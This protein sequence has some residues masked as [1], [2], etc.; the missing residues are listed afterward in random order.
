MI[1]TRT[2]PHMLKV[3]RKETLLALWFKHLA[4]YSCHEPIYVF[5]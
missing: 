5:R 4:Q 1:A 2:T 3:M